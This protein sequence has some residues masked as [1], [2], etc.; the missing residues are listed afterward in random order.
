[1]QGRSKLGAILA[2][3]CPRC[4]E[5]N[6]FEHS[7]LNVRH[8]SQTHVHCPVCGLRYEIEP[9]FFYGAMFI[10]YGFSVALLIVLGV[11]LYYFFNDPPLLTYILVV[12]FVTLL[13]VPP[14]YRYA[15][16]LMLH[17]FSGVRY[18]P[19]AAGK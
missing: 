10:S 17:W 15:R 5:G 16:I 7:L 2:E 12:T 6:V 18:Q 19:G 11:A 13:L 3:K 14:M 8:F 9:G 1:M 4:R